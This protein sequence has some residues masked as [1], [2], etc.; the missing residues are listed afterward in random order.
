[1]DYRQLENALEIELFRKENAILKQRNFELLET[2]K[3][4]KCEM[5]NIYVEIEG[6]CCIDF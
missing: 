6:R 5:S 1:M 4:L 2:I 3:D